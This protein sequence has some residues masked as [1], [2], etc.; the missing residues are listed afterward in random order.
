LA[1]RQPRSSSTAE[2]IFGIPA[3][4]GNA[5]KAFNLFRFNA[6]TDTLQLLGKEF[7]TGHYTTV[8][9]MSPD[10]KYVYYIPSA[11]SAPL[12]QYDIAE[13]R[14]KVIAFLAEPIDWRCGHLVS[15]PFGLKLSADGST[16]Y[17]N[18]TDVPTG[19]AGRLPNPS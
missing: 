8:C 13:D 1:S 5:N 14:R 16:I 19:L 4:A 2:K 11:L 9:V 7:T 6:R 15:L 18:S 17:A 12:V 10:E 3:P